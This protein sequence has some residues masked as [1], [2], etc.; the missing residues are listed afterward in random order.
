MARG[1]WRNND[2]YLALAI[3]IFEEKKKIMS[4]EDISEEILK[5]RRR[6]HGKT[7]KKSIYSALWNAEEISITK[8]GLFGLKEWG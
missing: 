3:R 1:V 7:P 5:K 2:T 8:D 4:L 6:K